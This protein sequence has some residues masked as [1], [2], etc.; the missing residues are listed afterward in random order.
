MR[1]HHITVFAF[2]MVAVAVFAQNG[3]TVQLPDVADKSK[4]P[5]RSSEILKLRFRGANAIDHRVKRLGS[6]RRALNQPDPVVQDQTSRQF[7]VAGSSAQ[8]GPPPPTA[9]ATQT[10]QTNPGSTTI[11]HQQRI[12]ASSVAA[13]E[14][15]GT[16]DV[17]VPQA[18][19]PDW[20][21]GIGADT[22]TVPGVPSDTTGAAGSTQY[23]Q[24]VNEA[25]A[26]F[27]KSTHKMTGPIEGR[28][29][30]KD[31]KRLP[32]NALHP[33]EKYND[34]D[35]IVAYDRIDDRWVLSQFAVANGPPFYECIAIS[36]SPDALGTY[37]R[38][39]F[40]FNKFNDYPKFAVWP[41]GYYASFNMFEPDDTPAGGEACVFN[42]AKMLSGDPSAEMICYHTSAGGLLPSDFDGPINRPPHPGA[43]FVN[44][45][46]NDS[47]NLWL[48]KPSWNTQPVSAS[49]T[50]PVRIPVPPF[51]I[52]CGDG[53]S[54]IPQKNSDQR[55]ESL[56]DRLLFRLAYREF[57]D[58]E[59]LLAMH[60]VQIPNTAGGSRTGIRWYEL[61]DLGNASPTVYQRS[62]YAPADDLSRWMG[63]GAF[64]KQGNLLI[65]YSAS[66][67]DVFPSIRYSGRLAGDE[68]NTLSAE[69]TA[70]DG[71]GS[72]GVDRWGDYSS[73][74][75]DPVDECTFW[76]TTEYLKSTGQYNWHTHI[77]KV[78]FPSCQ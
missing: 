28:A 37:F 50:G 22:Y 19:G 72:Q 7:G 61:R 64:D 65:A 73:V 10:T 20:F 66:G 18:A 16:M 51:T 32:G 6:P 21:E 55:L 69:R 3:P 45:T 4:A 25:L 74:T 48:L 77:R 54:C 15:G 76:I 14:N 60:A 9:A 67:K 44:F 57:A 46:S 53:G 26:V 13:V 42:K 38:Y 41:D 70:F 78:R 56:G 2:M 75:L 17:A 31:F 12:A 27:D 5:L 40:K 29:L 33:C 8:N 49:F 30:W 58:H 1:R 36:T 34:G 71:M 24:W 68:L 35:P 63:S 11:T 47:L 52:A 43:Y 62:T 39:A 59:S 23:V